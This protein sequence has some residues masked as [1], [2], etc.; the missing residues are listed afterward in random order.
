MLL[1]RALVAIILGPLTLFLIHLGGWFY[2]VPF[3]GLLIIATLEYSQL[4]GKLGW[5][6]PLWILLPATFLQWF[7][8]INVQEQLFSDGGISVNLVGPALVISLFGAMFYALWLYEKRVEDDAM[9]TWVATVSGIV[10]LGWL[11]SHFFRLRGIPESAAQWTALVIIGTWMAD[12]GAYAFGKTIGRH[13]LSP[14]LSPNKTIEG[15]VGGIIAGTITTILVAVFLELSLSTA[16]L[17]GLLVS[18]V[19]PAGDLGVSMLK[20]SVGVKDS[21]NILP[22]HGGALDRTDSLVWSVAMAYYL[23]LLIN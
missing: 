3:A 19:S 22:G 8:P 21:G 18:I 12:T 10:I 14:R 7:L 2:F 6:S 4:V 15:Y 16:I 11:G 17:I 13:K 9:A 20:R 23:I 5:K 1:Q